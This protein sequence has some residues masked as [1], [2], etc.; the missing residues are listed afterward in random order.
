VGMEQVIDAE[1]YI[2]RANRRIA[3]QRHLIARSRNP[4]TVAATQDL[5]EVLAALLA[6]VERQSGRES[7]RRDR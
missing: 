4:L 3:K 2:E 7:T 6:N 1:V 5:V